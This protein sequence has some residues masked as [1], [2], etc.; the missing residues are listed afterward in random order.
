SPPERRRLLLEMHLV[1]ALRRTIAATRPEVVISFINATNVRTLLA[2]RRL[3]VPVIVSER[4]DPYRDTL[5]EGMQR[6]RRRLYRHAAYVVCQTHDLAAL[7]ADEAGDR[8]RVVHTPV[9]RP[10]PSDEM[11]AKPARSPAA[12]TVVGMGRLAEEKGFIL[13]IRA[14]AAVAARHPSWSLEIWGEGPQRPRL[15][16]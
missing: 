9:L 16:R 10:P 2:T 8:V 5:N 12:R 15:E 11:R 14:F 6:L 1:A 4:T 3:G 7:F 13:L